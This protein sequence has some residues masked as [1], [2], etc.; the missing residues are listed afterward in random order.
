MSCLIIIGLWNRCRQFDS[1]NYNPEMKNVTET[2]V[3]LRWMILYSLHIT[4]LMIR[5]EIPRSFKKNPLQYI[6]TDIFG[7]FCRERAKL[8]R[9]S[10]TD[11]RSSDSLPPYSSPDGPYVS[12]GS[13]YIASRGYTGLYPNLQAVGRS[14]GLFGS[15]PPSYGGGRYGESPTT[16]FY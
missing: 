2:R 13:A 9:D 12:P 10:T 3:V 14:P 6:F 1:S 11:D 15:R 4:E 5:I 8:L 16:P 7:H